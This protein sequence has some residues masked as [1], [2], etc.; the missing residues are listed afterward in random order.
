M[1]MIPQ[2]HKNIK[3]RPIGRALEFVMGVFEGKG[4][5][6]KRFIL[7]LS[8]WE[9]N[10]RKNSLCQQL[11]HTF[12]YGLLTTGWRCYIYVTIYFITIDNVCM[13]CLNNLK[14]TCCHLSSILISI[15]FVKRRLSA[16]SI[17]N[18]KHSIMGRRRS[19]IMHD[20]AMFVCNNYVGR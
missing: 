17:I 7:T 16:T 14:S 10:R 15:C 20:L 9:A 19:K 2:T 6:K 12:I 13:I 8:F 4:V 18:M 1:R 5:L 11:F 3:P